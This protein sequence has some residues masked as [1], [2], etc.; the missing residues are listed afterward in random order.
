MVGIADGICD[1]GHSPLPPISEC[2][3][4]LSMGPLTPSVDAITLYVPSLRKKTY[5]DH[6]DLIASLAFPGT[7][8]K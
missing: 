6:V 7:N 1:P 5:P 2:W 8:P 4:K 3:K